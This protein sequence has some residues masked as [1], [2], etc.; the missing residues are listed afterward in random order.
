MNL[1]FWNQI[2]TPKEDE[3]AQVMDDFMNFADTTIALNL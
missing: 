1:M 3:L 2:K